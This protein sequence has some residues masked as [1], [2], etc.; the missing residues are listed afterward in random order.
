VIRGLGIAT[1]FAVIGI[2]AVGQAA[3][4][5]EPGWL[6]IGSQGNNPGQFL[7][8]TG[9]AVDN[10]GNLYVAERGNNRIQKLSPDDEPLAQWGSQGN[11]LGQFYGPCG[12]AV[13]VQGNVYVVETLGDRVQKFSPQG[14]PLAQWGTA[15]GP[16]HSEAGYQDPKSVAV[17]S[18]GDVYSVV[19][20]GNG[21]DPN[22]RIREL[23]PDGNLLTELGSFGDGPG[24]FRY[25]TGLTVDQAGNV[26]VADGVN[27]SVQKLSPDGE[28]LA[29]WDLDSSLQPIGLAL[30]TQGN[31]YVVDQVGVQKLSAE[32]EVLA[33]WNDPAGGEQPGQF[34]MST[35][36]AVDNQGS[37]YVA[38]SFNNR[39]QKRSS[40]GT[41]AG[42]VVPAPGATASTAEDVTTTAPATAP[43]VPDT[44]TAGVQAD[45]LAAVDRANSAWAVA[46]ESL[47]PSGLSAGV[48][49]QELEDDLAELDQLRSR[50]Q[51]KQNVNTAF[52][53]TDVTLD[54][55]GHATVHTTETWSGEIDSASGGQPIQRLTPTSYTETYTVEFQNG[56]WIVTLNQLAQT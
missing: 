24:Q 49:G 47:D 7:N 51:K 37:V 15:G 9:V 56:G 11:G 44:L 27:H 29:R 38:D 54:A 1:A 5:D 2:S 19:N 16:V 36:V 3:R 52:A 48:A 14:K 28:P 43:A 32:G 10:Q 22:P 12:V 39:V 53:V 34:S 6:V 25:P 50:G 17:N 41:A 45:I 21:A 30:D 33:D 31:L 4:A 55:P 18:Q 20:A 40:D 46:S 35:G 42:I 8:P 26:Y 13:D 23:S